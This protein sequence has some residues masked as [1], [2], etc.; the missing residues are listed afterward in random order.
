MAQGFVSDTIAPSKNRLCHGTADNITTTNKIQ[1]LTFNDE[2]SN[3]ETVKNKETKFNC[4][5]QVV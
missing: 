1:Q 5:V 3:K 2:N 4:T